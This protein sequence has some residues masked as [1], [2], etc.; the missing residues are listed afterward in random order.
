MSAAFCTLDDLL[1]CLAVEETTHGHFT[2]PNLELPYYRIF[3]GQLLAQTIAIATR[4]GIEK[5]VKSMHVQQ[6]Q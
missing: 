1:A 4:E 5:H 6:M 3:G 2:G